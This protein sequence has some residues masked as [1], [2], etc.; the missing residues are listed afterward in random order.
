MAGT[1]ESYFGRAVREMAGVT[2]GSFTIHDDGA[3]I[4][5]PTAAEVVKKPP[6]KN[7]KESEG[8]KEVRKL[9]GGNYHKNN[10]VPHSVLAAHLQYNQRCWLTLSIWFLLLQ[11]F[12][13][14]AIVEGF[15]GDAANMMTICRQAW[16]EMSAVS[17]WVKAGQ[18][19]S[20]AKKY[21]EV[22][23]KEFRY[24]DRSTQFISDCFY[25]AYLEA[26]LITG[27]TSWIEFYSENST[28]GFGFWDTQRVLSSER[29]QEI[30]DCDLPVIQKFG[31]VSGISRNALEDLRAEIEV[32][33]E[34]RGKRKDLLVLWDET[35]ERN[36]E[37][38]A[39]EAGESAQEQNTKFL[40]GK[41]FQAESTCVIAS[42]LQG[43]SIPLSTSEI[44]FVRELLVCGVSYKGLVRLYSENPLL[45][46]R[47]LAEVRQIPHKTLLYQKW[48]ITPDKG[49]SCCGTANAEE[50]KRLKWT[51]DG[52]TNRHGSWNYL[53]SNP[54]N[55]FLLFNNTQLKLFAERG[56]FPS[57]VSEEWQ[58]I[59]RRLTSSKVVLY[60]GECYG[61]MP[62]KKPQLGEFVTKITDKLY[63]N[64]DVSDLDS[65]LGVLVCPK[66]SMPG[67]PEWS[68]KVSPLRTNSHQPKTAFNQIL[69]LRPASG[70]CYWLD[71]KMRIFE[72]G[73]NTSRHAFTSRVWAYQSLSVYGASAFGYKKNELQGWIR[74]NMPGSAQ[75]GGLLVVPDKDWDAM[76]FLFERG[77]F[78][79]P[80]LVEH[81][82]VKNNYIPSHNGGLRKTC[83][84][85]LEEVSPFQRAKQN[86]ACASAALMLQSP[87]LDM[88]R[89][90][91]VGYNFPGGYISKGM[92]I[93]EK[94]LEKIKPLD[95]DTSVSIMSKTAAY[96]MGC[97]CVAYGTHRDHPVQGFLAVP[98]RDEKGRWDWRKIGDF[99]CENPDSSFPGSVLRICPTVNRIGYF[100]N[101]NPIGGYRT[102]KGKKMD[103][104]TSRLCHYERYLNAYKPLNI[105]FRSDRDYLQSDRDSSDKTMQGRDAKKGVRTKFLEW[106]T[107]CDQ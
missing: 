14:K 53:T 58:E 54:C 42:A 45:F 6:K 35:E 13:E 22:F 37:G 87:N 72:S 61:F 80:Q 106:R 34:T 100:Q 44:P 88:T 15:I 26:L 102:F 50:R 83:F 1:F 7:G 101:C 96:E 46:Y 104:S 65:G 30:S 74:L 60:N 99:K 89:Y 103:K 68:R 4:M 5:S 16:T 19:K 59:G 25:F 10:S 66:R 92:K 31:Y 52:M 36:K 51:L 95:F 73:S 70:S 38:K 47:S 28:L 55:A 39:E 86:P 20:N 69:V 12:D 81:H 71:K 43:S 11:G 63:D 57:G 49:L 79:I 24:D 21:S 94:K 3:V 97:V 64:A 76:S 105:G 56:D 29:L 48:T 85:G 32:V 23:Q 40:K 78:Y 41:D 18:S 17:G 98:E 9:F 2:T 91:I 90:G 75:T 27:D 93:L 8:S 62:S 107:L 82:G 67:H 77:L 33:L 84:G